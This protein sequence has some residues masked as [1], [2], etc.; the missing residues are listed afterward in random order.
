MTG[1]DKSNKI[2]VIS[3]AV[4]D[5]LSSTFNTLTSMENYESKH[6]AQVSNLHKFVHSSIIPVSELK[7]FIPN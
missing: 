7:K 5:Y 1:N 2:A 3:M 4:T 6:R